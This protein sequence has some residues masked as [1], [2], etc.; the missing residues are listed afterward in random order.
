MKIAILGC[1]KQ[2]AKHVEGLRAVGDTELVLYDRDVAF[3]RAL[4]E[5]TG[6]PWVAEL[7]EVLSDPT[8]IAVD[9]ATPTPSHAE[10]LTLAIAA[11]KHF[12]CE[13]PLCLSSAEAG[14][15]QRFSRERGCVGMVGYIYRFSPVFAEIDRLLQ[16]SVPEVRSPAIGRVNSAILRLGGRG[17][18]QAWKHNLSTG[19]GALNE[20]MVHMVDLALWYFGAAAEASLVRNELLRP[21]RTIA[22]EAVEADAPDYCVALLRSV[23]GVEILIQSDLLTPSF[24]QFVEIQGDNGSILASIQDTVTSYVFCIEEA[25]GFQQG[26]TEMQF[27][28]RNLFHT[29]MMEFVTAIREKR[30]PHGNSIADSLTLL[31][32]LEKLEE[33]IP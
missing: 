16:R 25:G 4:G 10:L 31:R 12:F 15:I 2:G 23:T 6:L 28:K 14:E 24:S 33:K 7:D 26:R 27:G 8:V 30:E 20:M 3:S 19:G 22:G 9:V 1:G 11:G 13:K 18:H 21:V 32:T 29:Q 17:S 5:Q